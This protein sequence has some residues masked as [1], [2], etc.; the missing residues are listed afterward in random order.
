MTFIA[1]QNLN[2]CA[3]SMNNI[4]SC[5]S[6]SIFFQISNNTTRFKNLLTKNQLLLEKPLQIFPDFIIKFSKTL[7]K[8]NRLRKG[9]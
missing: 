2:H 8:G 3:H 5:H 7:F 4:V 6:P 1:M 9:K